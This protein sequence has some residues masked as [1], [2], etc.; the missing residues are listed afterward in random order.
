MSNP[1]LIGA[2]NSARADAGAQPPPPSP[3]MLT[4]IRID[5][6]P[7]DV[8]GR[9]FLLADYALRELGVTLGFGTFD[10]VVA[11]N[12]ANRDTW[13]PLLPMFHPDNGLMDQQWAY[14]LIGRNPQG[15]TMTV[16]SARVFDWRQTDVA[17]EARSL[18]LFYSDPAAMARPNE[19]CLVTTPSA[20]HLNGLVAFSGAAWWHPSVRGKLIG[21]ILSRV[22]RAYAY[23]RWQ[24]DLTLAMMAKGLIEKGFAGQ[25]GYRHAEIGLVLENF[26]IGAY[27]GGFVWITA[28]EIIDDLVAFS[29]ELESRLGNVA[30]LRRA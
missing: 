23:T 15:K 10:D 8:L 27:E 29:A 21:A 16:Q 14:T 30:R 1:K 13:R 22:S 17:T 26:E 11:T 7:Q 6:G 12:N 3:S 24:T 19:T 9:F 4:D 2:L 25:N 20:P 18:R 28:D 5:F